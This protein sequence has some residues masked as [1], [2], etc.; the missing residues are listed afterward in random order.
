[1]SSTPAG[2]PLPPFLPTDPSLPV[3]DPEI[4]KSL[5]LGQSRLPIVQ[6]VSISLAHSPSS[7]TCVH[8]T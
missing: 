8:G 2:L 4:L 6:K 1:M 3:K 7:Q 5:S